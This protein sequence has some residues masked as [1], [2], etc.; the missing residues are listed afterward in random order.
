M[1]TL[2]TTNVILAIMAAASVIQLLLV[3]AA[4][5][6]I[7]RQVAHLKQE[8]RQVQVRTDALVAQIHAVAAQAEGAMADLRTIAARADGVGRELERVGV[9]LQEMVRGIG[10]EVRRATDGVHVAMDIV[11]A[12]YHGATAI[13]DTVRSGLREFFRGRTRHPDAPPA[14]GPETP[15]APPAPG[16]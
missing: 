13:G 6:W 9:L 5:Y 2:D 8:L 3:L 10:I 4:A 16:A 14:A 11:E 12:A 15:P 7:V 1:D